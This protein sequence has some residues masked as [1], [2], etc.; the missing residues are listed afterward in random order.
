MK[1]KRNEVI[2]KVNVKM[3]CKCSC[4]A[5]CDCGCAI[6]KGKGVTTGTTNS[7][8]VDAFECSAAYFRTNNN[9]T[10]T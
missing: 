7:G 8:S 10:D 5:P 1:K 3:G 4:Y 6:S 2:Q 9:S